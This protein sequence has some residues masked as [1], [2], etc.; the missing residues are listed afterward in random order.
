MSESADRHKTAKKEAKA[1]LKRQK[2]LGLQQAAAERPGATPNA[3]SMQ[4]IRA[5]ERSAAAAE[6]QVRLQQLRVWLA[7]ATA[8]I[9]FLT[10]L[11]TIRPWER[12]QRPDAPDA[13]TSTEEVGSAS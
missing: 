12:L 7:L 6:R 3:S 10:L 4:G 1:E 5:A 9:A 8:L 13:E 11:A 2:K